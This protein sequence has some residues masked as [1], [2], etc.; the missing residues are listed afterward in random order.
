M[1]CDRY[2]RTRESAAPHRGCR[3]ERLL[4]AVLLIC[5]IGMS[6]ACSR[7]SNDSARSKAAA[8]DYE[9]LRHRT[10]PAFD[11]R[12]RV[13]ANQ[14]RRVRL[15]FQE[16]EDGDGSFI[17]FGPEGIVPGRIISGVE[18]LGRAASARTLAELS[19]TSIVLEQRPHRWSLVSEGLLLAEWDNPPGEGLKMAFGAQGGKAKFSVRFQPVPDL[20]FADS[21]MR[22]PEDPTSWTEVSGAWELNVRSDPLLSANAFSYRGV[23]APIAA[24]V[25]GEWFWSDIVVQ[26]ACRP[27][28]EGAVGLYLCYRGPEDYFL[29]RWGSRDS[30]KPVRQLIRRVGKEDRVLAEAPGGYAPGQWCTLK[31]LI[32]SGWVRLGVDDTRFFVVRD[33][34]LTYGRIGLHVAGAKPAIFDDVKVE[35]RYASCVDFDRYHLDQRLTTGGEWLQVAPAAWDREAWP[36]GLVVRAPKR[37]Q[38]I[39]GNS[40]WRRY[41][42]AALLGPWQKGT[43][44]LCFRYQDDLN[45]Y[46]VRWQKGSEPVIQLCR[47]E[48]G[49]DKVLAQVPFREDSESH[50]LGVASEGGSIVVSVDNRPVLRTADFGFL[51]GRCGLF[52]QAIGSGNF[53]DVTYDFLRGRRPIAN[54][55]RAFSGEQSMSL[56]AAALSDWSKSGQ[57]TADGKP[58]E[59]HWRRADFHGGLRA[60]VR[61]PA[62][63]EAG[64]ELGLVLNGNGEDLREGFL[65]RLRRPPAEGD[66]P[67]D[68]IVELASGEKPLASKTISW[69]VG[70]RGF[71]LQRVGKS[72]AAF[73]DDDLLLTLDNAD[74]G[75]GRKFGWY[76]M[77]VPLTISDFDIYSDNIVNYTFNLAPTDWR[78]GAGTWELTSKWQCDPRWSFFSGRSDK[79]A[80][81]WNKRPLRGDFTIEFYVGNK[82][83]RERGGKYEYARDMNITVCADGEDLTSGYTFL[84][85]GFDDTVT[86]L[87]RGDEQF[88]RPARGKEILIE[89]SGNL[90]RR[91]YHVQVSRKG[92]CLEMRIDNRLVLSKTDDNPLTGGHWALW[93]W[94]NGITVARVQ[95]AAEQ[96]GERSSPDTVWPETTQAFYQ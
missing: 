20:F 53:S 59:I 74:P 24:S 34:G 78:V 63:P 21:F 39:W 38:L 29:F 55:R 19:D 81:L 13:A 57:T 14:A 40:S 85:G 90:H 54:V 10:L 9:F 11:L 65:L 28:P 37:A 52:A 8:W 33:P 69:K 70:P 5:L 16:S 22:T 58:I 26:A 45:Y 71:A 75:T 31:A 94:N 48:R 4:L 3:A 83:Q 30:E 93:T 42:L 50:R 79:L 1:M 44:G 67:G 15:F 27:G 51:G 76:A 41:A 62:P 88:C 60:E 95:V 12:F 82:M 77:N 84:F 43:L 73:S 35:S 61:L 56:W 32:G 7:R 18:R 47:T 87:Y 6:A 86:A 80:V 96:T 92:N 49:Q 89:R 91:W 25:V 2:E 46:S 17:Q 68:M 64:A 66:A 72:L 36:G 23:G